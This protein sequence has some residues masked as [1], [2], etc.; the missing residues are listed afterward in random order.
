MRTEK[1]VKELIND[2]FR[3]MANSSSEEVTREELIIYLTR[4]SVLHWVLGE[5]E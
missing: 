3:E 5:N 2:N 4:L 1:E